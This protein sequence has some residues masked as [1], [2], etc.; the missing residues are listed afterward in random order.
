[1]PI[2]RADLPAFLISDVDAHVTKTGVWVYVGGGAGS[3]T[4][5]PASPVPRATDSQTY[6]IKVRASAGALTLNRSNADTFAHGAGNPTSITLQ[7]GQ[8][9]LLVPISGAVWEVLFLPAA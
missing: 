8:S 1:M 6:F 2:T 7:P 3:W 5:A 9:A 4:I